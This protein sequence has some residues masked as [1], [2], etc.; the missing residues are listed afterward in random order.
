MTDLKYLANEVMRRMEYQKTPS[1]IPNEEYVKMVINSIKELYILTGRAGTF[2]FNLI[3]FELLTYDMTFGI[4]EIEFILVSTQI[5]FL[6]KVQA[7][8]N[9]QVSYTTD[10]LSVTKAD[11]PYKNLSG[12][13]A[14]L[15]NK[16]RIIFYKM[17]AY[18]MD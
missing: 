3:D 15:K 9:A 18:V 17:V 6:E 7:G 13:I 12:S 10:A 1:Q 5:S 11:M 4:D 8:V 14:E 2:D 16:R